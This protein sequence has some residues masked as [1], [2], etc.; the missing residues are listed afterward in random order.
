M[1]VRLAEDAE[2]TERITLAEQTDMVWH[3]YLPDV[4]PG[5][6]YGYRVHGPYEPAEGPPLQPE[7]GAARPV[8]QGDRPRRRSGPT[9]CSATTSATKQADLSFDERDSAAD[10]PLGCVIDEAFTWG[11]DRPPQTPWHKTLIYEMHVKGFTKLH[12]EVPEEL[13]GTYAGLSLRAGDPLPAATWASRPSNCC[14]CTTTS[15]TASWSSKGLVNYWGYNTLGFF[16]PEPRYAVGRATRRRDPRIQD[17]GPQ[18]ARRRA[19]R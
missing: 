15:T 11:D 8:R 17:D 16:A 6:L 19:S 18:P 3:C 14:R 13:R 2:E 4:R 9:R 7:Q 5:Q 10:A 12:P 1:P